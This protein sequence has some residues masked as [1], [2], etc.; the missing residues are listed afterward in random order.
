MMIMTQGSGVSVWGLG[1]PRLLWKWTR[2]KEVVARDRPS[3]QLPTARLPEMPIGLVTEVVAVW[4]RR[5][6]AWMC[7]E[8]LN[9]LSFGLRVA[10]FPAPMRPSTEVYASASTLTRIVGLAYRASRT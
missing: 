4:L 1:S 8:G 5:P 10:G 3:G 6:V 7:P 9:F 2:D